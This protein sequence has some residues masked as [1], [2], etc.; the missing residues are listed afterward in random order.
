MRYGVVELSMLF[1]DVRGS[2]KI[3]RTM[4]NLEFSR[5]MN[6]FYRVSKEVLVEDEGAKTA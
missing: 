4:S 2:S 1:A 3:A 6:R 5:L